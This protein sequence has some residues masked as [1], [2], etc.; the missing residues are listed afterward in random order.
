MAYT[1]ISVHDP[2]L[3]GNGV[4][5]AGLLFGATRLDIPA[6]CFG[7]TDTA[8]LERTLH[9]P[10]VY[11]LRLTDAVVH[12]PYGIVTIGDYVLQETLDHTPL[13]PPGDHRGGVQVTV[14]TAG[15]GAVQ[16]AA[17]AAMGGNY[18]NHFHFAAEILPRLQIEPLAPYAYNGSVLFPPATTAPL[19][20]MVALLTAAQRS[21]Y[22][23][24]GPDAVH[25]KSLNFVPNLAG[26][27]YAPHPGL[28]SFFDNLKRLL[29]I[30]GGGNRRIY[31]A[32]KD[33][34]NRILVNEDEVIE[35]VRRAGFEIVNL[36]G[37]GLT[38]QAQIF[39]NAS[40]VIA[41]HGA[42]LANLLFCS[43]GVIVCE[44]HMSSYL[45]WCIRRI[46]GIR[47]IRYGCI[48]GAPT[49]ESEAWVHSQRWELDP[50]KLDAVLDHP[51][52]LRACTR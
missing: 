37:L 23:L 21:V 44:L 41:P 7:D 5:P 39:A 18:T 4:E 51:E 2:R 47:G 34:A 12:P 35:R 50:A 20:E 10:D 40:H 46:G 6:I 27:G 17:I 13:R 14:P 11:R 24:G 16:A 49:N 52:F 1:T 29:G 48:V 26:A 19:R 28:A 25:V 33:S 42:G 31:V 8:P 3:L 22:S 9:L 45:N 30:N 32:R 15:I 36:S 38:E 43:P